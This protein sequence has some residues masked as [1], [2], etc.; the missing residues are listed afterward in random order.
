AAMGRLEEAE[1]SLLRAVALQ[2]G[3]VEAY[4]N[5]GIVLRRRGRLGESSEALSR[6]VTLRPDFDL[7][8]FHRA[9]TALQGGDAEG[10]RRDL[11][12]LRGRDPNL[13]ARLAAAL[14]AA[15]RRLSALLHLRRRA[16]ERRE[17]SVRL[18]GVQQ[19]E[20]EGHAAAVGAAGV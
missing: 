18:A 14:E 8:R 6:A 19:G 17:R 16:R 15:A 5:L 10:A 1:A 9:I 20:R 13:A 4:L 11:D 7:A 3:F 2:P 12:V